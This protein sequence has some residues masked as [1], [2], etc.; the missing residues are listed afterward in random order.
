MPEGDSIRR[1]ANQLAPLAGK[2][3]ERVTTQGLPRAIEGRT[4]T[5]VDAHVGVNGRF[6]HYDRATGDSLLGRMSP[7]RAS[8]ALVVT[9]AGGRRA[10][11]R[12]RRSP[13]PVAR[14]CAEILAGS[15]HWGC[16]WGR[17]LAA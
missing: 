1:I 17:Q 12:D 7:G 13:R 3:L 5:A 16:H 2:Q 14:A 9:D 4:V 11:D 6:R 10:H 8:L 15:T